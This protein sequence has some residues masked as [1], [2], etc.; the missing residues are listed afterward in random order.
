VS[1]VSCKHCVD[2]LVD[3]LEGHLPPEKEKALDEHFMACPPC[4]DFLDQYRAASSLS[5]RAL[6]ME[7]PPV[8]AEK[9]DEFLRKHCK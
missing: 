6:E 3:Y 9:L 7:I 1:T 2:L 8:L 5:R 4:L